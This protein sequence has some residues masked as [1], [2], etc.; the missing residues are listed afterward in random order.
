MAI[1]SFLTVMLSACSKHSNLHHNFSSYGTSHCT[2]PIYFQECTFTQH[3]KEGLLN[4]SRAIFLLSFRGSSG[5]DSIE[6]NMAG[7]IS[8]AEPC[9]AKTCRKAFSPFSINIF[10]YKG[11]YQ[12]HPIPSLQ[13]WT[14]LGSVSHRYLARFQRDTGACRVQGC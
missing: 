14:A 5:R 1:H 11:P 6:D 8:L 9:H 12:H 13:Q 4:C 3:D 10:H 7:F 2:H